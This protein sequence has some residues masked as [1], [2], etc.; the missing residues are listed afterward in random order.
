MSSVPVGGHGS[1][2]HTADSEGAATAAPSPAQLSS[3]LARI[4][5]YDTNSPPPP[6]SVSDEDPSATGGAGG[7]ASLPGTPVRGGTSADKEEEDITTLQ[8][9]PDL[10]R[11]DYARSQPMAVPGTEGAQVVGE[12]KEIV[13]EPSAMANGED[14]YALVNFTEEMIAGG[15][16]EQE[17]ELIKLDY[18]NGDFVLTPHHEHIEAQLNQAVQA[19]DSESSLCGTITVNGNTTHGKSYVLRHLMGEEEARPHCFPESRQ[20]FWSTTG[21]VCLY[22][23]HAIDAERMVT[24]LDFEGEG[25]ITDPLMNAVRHPGEIDKWRSR[26]SKRQVAVRRFFPKLAYTLGDV[27]LSVSQAQ[28]QDGERV[29]YLCQFARQA[30]TGVDQMSHLPAL[31]LIENKTSLAVDFDITRTTR[32]FEELLAQSE[33]GVELMHYYSEIHCI[34]LPRVAECGTG[35]TELVKGQ[36]LSGDVVFAKQITKLRAL[37]RGILRRREE[38]TLERLNFKGWLQLVDQVVRRVAQGQAVSLHSLV[39]EIL[40]R[41]NSGGAVAYEVFLTLTDR[42]PCCD[43][44]TF[45]MNRKFAIAYLARTLAIIF[46]R[47]EKSLLMTSAM[48]THIKKEFHRLWAGL[49]GFTPCESKYTGKGTPALPRL[50]LKGLPVDDSND[51]YCY[52]HKGAHPNHRTSRD[53]YG[54]DSVW[55]K[56]KKLLG[57]G[58]RAVWQG[59]FESTDTEKAEDYIQQF[60][61]Q[62]LDYYRD[63]KR[64]FI[65]RSYDTLL[66]RGA[67]I[68]GL[69]RVPVVMVPDDSKLILPWDRKRDI[70]CTCCLSV[71]KRARELDK[72]Q[73]GSKELRVCLECARILRIIQ[74][75][76]VLVGEGMIHVFPVYLSSI[77]GDA[78]HAAGITSGLP[79][80]DP[81]LTAS[82]LPAA[83]VSR[84]RQP[85]SSIRGLVH[86]DPVVDM[87][88]ELR[89]VLDIGKSNG[90]PLDFPSLR[91]RDPSSQEIGQGIEGLCQSFEECPPYVISIMGPRHT[92]KTRIKNML[93]VTP[94][95]EEHTQ[96]L[97]FQIAPW[98]E[99]MRN[100]VVLDT[101]G[102]VLHTVIHGEGHPSGESKDRELNQLYTES[103]IRDVG[104]TLCDLPIIVVGAGESRGNV[105]AYILPQLARMRKRFGEFSSKLTVIHYFDNVR[106]VKVLFQRIEED[107]IQKWK[108]EQRE[109]PVVVNWTEQR[110]VYYESESIQHLIMAHDDSKAGDYCNAGTI[111]LIRKLVATGGHGQF[112]PRTDLFA[113]VTR[114]IDMN[115]NSFVN[116]DITVVIRANKGAPPRIMSVQPITDLKYRDSDELYFDFNLGE[117]QRMN[118]LPEEPMSPSR[119]GLR[120]K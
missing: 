71:I 115:I 43:P 13:D 27:L 117:V 62:V 19:A 87:T 58:Y 99:D 9:N 68:L 100:L 50:S 113:E 39:A 112:P 109:V 84:D 56:F 49:D 103:L 82:T 38:Q 15:H 76:P 48:E 72:G 2:Y 91:P 3:S 81:T 101:P 70:L 18:E 66:G 61:G 12:E 77:L 16:R 59:P 28:L 80:N 51:V 110:V 67:S 116:K 6:V 78:E 83:H 89:S 92:G 69:S 47:Q 64:D 36:V 106:T 23:T 118:Q 8:A 17:H 94:C 95:D 42:V 25:A 96:V 105:N 86:A 104:W 52:Q 85:D 20:D 90:F 35:P 24:C 57:I 79:P 40:S 37:I 63:G 102:E 10:S 30:N 73:E 4:S 93:C 60:K 120:P 34:R 53:V 114:A 74:R 111:A 29:E 98:T 44:P 33:M 26:A 88:I 97:G 75:A 11:P 32:R 22:K 31:I 107:I 108:A 21:N 55:E 119:L 65:Y 46:S 14:P 5:V 54:G 41:G 7:N 45:R 1:L